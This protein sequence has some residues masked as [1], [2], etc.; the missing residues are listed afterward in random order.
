MTDGVQVSRN[1][2]NLS[3]ALNLCI[4]IAV[5]EDVFQQLVFPDSSSTYFTINKF[6]RKNFLE[7]HKV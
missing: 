1:L 3:N 6:C 4:G 2:T 5:S 7:N